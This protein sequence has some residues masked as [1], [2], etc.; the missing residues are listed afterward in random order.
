M[1]NMLFGGGGFSFEPQKD[2]PSLQGKVILV[3]GGNIG[4]GKQAILEYAQ[5]GPRQIWLAARNL[6][7]AKAAADEIQ[8]Q[9]PDAPIKL[10]RLDLE[11]FESVNEAAKTFAAESDRLDILMLNAGI[12]ASTPGLTEQG[13]AIQFGTNHMGHALL[14]KLLLPVLDKTAKSGTDADVRVVSL[15]STAH[16]MLPKGGSCSSPSRRRR[17]AWALSSDT[18]R[19]SSQTSSSPGSSPRSVPSSPSP[20]F[21]PAS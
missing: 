1:F 4:L 14:T 8:S 5:H 10:L 13:Y 17:I 7:K 19:A 18:V 9:A 20:R 3:T 15:S 16:R 12:M 2:V 6:D 21:I 11:S